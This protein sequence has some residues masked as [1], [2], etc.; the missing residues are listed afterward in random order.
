LGRKACVLNVKINL[1]IPAQSV[2]QPSIQ[3]AVNRVVA[4]LQ[5]QRMPRAT[6][7]IPEMPSQILVLVFM[8]WNSYVYRT[9]CK[10]RS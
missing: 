9:D 5:M 7:R 3:A 4:G 10:L 8:M 2:K 6:R 1:A